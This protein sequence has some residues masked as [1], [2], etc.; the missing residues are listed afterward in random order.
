MAGLSR[1]LVLFQPFMLL[2]ALDVPRILLRRLK[3]S[4]MNG[5]DP[6]AEVYSFTKQVTSTFPIKALTPEDKVLNVDDF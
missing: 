4:L 3:I 2:E 6:N 1:H 5:R